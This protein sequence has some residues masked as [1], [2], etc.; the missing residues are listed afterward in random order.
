MKIEFISIDDSKN[1]FS[2]PTPATKHIPK[3]YKEMP[4]HLGD[5]K[6]SGLSLPNGS[7]PNTTLKSCVPF[8]DAMSIGYVWSAPVDIEVRNFSGSYLF[9]WRDTSRQYITSHNEDQ[10]LG[11]PA[12]AE[13]SNE[14][15]NVMKW[16]MDY[17]IKTPPGYST[18][19]TH[20][21]NR[22]ELPFRTLT[23]VVDTDTYPLP[24]Q[25]PFE[26]IVNIQEDRPLIIEQ[27]TP[28][29]QFFPILRED[30]KSKNK[31]IDR[32]EYEKNI[33]DFQSKIVRSY[34]NKF[35]HKKSF[36]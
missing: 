22:N 16:S 33:W 3:W 5:D 26:I 18:I 27:G 31:I 12:P 19:F 13:L 8:L 34:K 6:T 36:T 21:H 28:L 10:Y 24:I 30:W 4:R 20:P 1:F 29:C 11:L 14:K 2:P 15:R 35:W 7:S 25:F 32:K 17:L 9:R 23:G